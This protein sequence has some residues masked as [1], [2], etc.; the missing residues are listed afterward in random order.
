[1]TRPTPSVVLRPVDPVA[2]AAL[3]TGWVTAERSTFW[4]MSELS[5]EDVQEIYTYIDEQAHLAAY[6]I[7][8][9]GLPIGLLQTYDPEVDEIGE[10]Y[11]REPGDIGVHF[12]LAHDER[13]A[14]RTPE[15]L[16]AGFDFVAHL[17]GCRRLV[18]EPDARNAASVALLDRLGAERGPLVDLR[19][20]ISEKPAQFFFIS[21]EQVLAL[22]GA[23]G[24]VG[25]LQQG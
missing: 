12:L 16:A 13:R 17:P 5:Q 3:L 18:F 10:W 19:T 20:S 6:L 23:E 8:L 2:D 9:D 4:G 15:L 7:L 21:R 25:L 1:M 11:D 22:A 24:V 14:G